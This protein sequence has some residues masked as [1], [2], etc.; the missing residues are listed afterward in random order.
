MLT[1]RTKAEYG[2]VGDQLRPRYIYQG[3]GLG[4]RNINKENEDTSKNNETET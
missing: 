3:R 2:T 4:I 1:S